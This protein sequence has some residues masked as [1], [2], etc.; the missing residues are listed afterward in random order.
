M[1]FKIKQAGGNPQPPCHCEGEARGNPGGVMRPFPT[2]RIA[3]TRL[4]RGVA[5]TVENKVG[6]RVIE[7]HRPLLSVYLSRKLIPAVFLDRVYH[8]LDIFRLGSVGQ[9]G[10]GGENE[11]AALTSRLEQVF[12]VVLDFRW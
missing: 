3:S 9:A 6:G 12:A 5:I 10:A 11:A 1:F 7:T 4:R 2:T 8:R